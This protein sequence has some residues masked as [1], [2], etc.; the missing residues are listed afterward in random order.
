MT[1]TLAQLT[2][3][4]AALIAA[5]IDAVE[6]RK[7]WSPF[8][9][10]PSGKFHAPGKADEGK[11]AFE[12]QLGRPFDLEQPGITGRSG[13]EVSPFTRKALGISYPVSNPEKLIAAASAAMSGWR[14]VDPEARIALCLEMAMRLYARNFEM[15]HSVMHVA[16]QSYTQA[17]SGSGP[18]A[19]D[20]GIEALAY[21]AKAMRAVAPTARWNRT[22]G[23]EDVSLDKAYTL[24]PRGIGLVICCASFPTWNAYPAMFASLATGNPVIVKPHPIAI[25]PM[26]IAVQECRRALV[27]YGCDAN[28]VTL[29]VDTLDA[30]IA[31]RFIDDPAVQI[32]DFTGS[33]RYGGHLERTITGKQLFTETAGINS[34]VLESCNDLEATAT[35]IARATSLFSAQMCTSPQN[36]YVPASGVETR[37]GHATFEDVAQVLVAA[38]DTIANNPPLAAGIMGAVQAQPSCETVLE[39][40]ERAQAHPQA[41]VLRRPTSYLH[42]D[43][44]EARTMTPLVVALPAGNGALYAEE[45]FGPVLFVIAAE[46]GDAGVAEATAL[47]R[48][49]GAISSYLYSADEAFIDR[50]LDAYAESGMN[51]SINLHGAMWANFAAAYSDYHVTGLNPAGNACLADLAFVVSRFCIVQHRRPAKRESQSHAA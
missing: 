50:S 20:R 39:L 8:R 41:K 32:I 48:E 18:N 35:A 6:T 12:A 5:A 27:D 34:V 37:D 42:P 30:P 25:L 28:L 29:A 24:V 10:S 17:F 36:V 46:S 15:A 40:E 22:F 26:A 21:A 51:L 2:E 44:P 47:A 3:R 45:H 31:Q 7:N 14:K 43:F 11:A 19:L 38:I 13:D 9:D 49:H 1:E 16:G 4:H 33:P 23:K